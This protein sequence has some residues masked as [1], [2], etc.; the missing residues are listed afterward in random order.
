MPIRVCS[1]EP[2]TLDLAAM[3]AD[4]MRKDLFLEVDWMR[5]GPHSRGH[6]PRKWA[7]RKLVDA[8]R[9][10]P[11]SNPDGSTGIS[12][13]VD[14]GPW[15]EMNPVTGERWGANS[16]SNSIAHIDRL[17]S[18]EE[19]GGPNGCAAND[20]LTIWGAFDILKLGNL[21]NARNFAKVRGPVFR[22]GVLAHHVD[23]NASGAGPPRTLG[24]AR[25]IES[26]D[27]ILSLGYLNP[28][29]GAKPLEQG[30]TMMHEFGHALGL[31]HGGQDDTNLKPNYVS[32]MNYAFSRVGVLRNDGGNALQYSGLGALPDLDEF[33]LDE[34]EGIAGL[35]P[36]NPTA[37]ASFGTRWA[38]PAGLCSATTTQRCTFDSDCPSA[39]FCGTGVCSASLTVC[40]DD[41]DCPGIEFCAFAVCSS[42]GTPCASAATCPAGESCNDLVPPIGRN[43]NAA[44]VL[45]WN[46]NGSTDVSLVA[47]DVNASSTGD[48]LAGNWNDWTSLVYTADHVGSL[49]EIPSSTLG[50]AN[51]DLPY[52][53]LRL[54]RRERDVQIEADGD[55]GLRPGASTQLSFS[56]QNTGEVPDTYS[57][58]LVSDQGFASATLPA[59]VT[60]D[61]DEEVAI[62]ID[63]DVPLATP[64]GV[65]EEVP[66]EAP[67]QSDPL[68]TGLDGTIVDVFSCGDVNLDSIVDDADVRD[69]RAA[70][71]RPLSTPLGFEGEQRCSVVGGPDDCDLLDLVL[72]QRAVNAPVAAPGIAQ[73]CRAATL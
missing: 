28:S 53:I 19:I 39:E 27:F 16:Q 20:F 58:A 1:Y 72:L 60:L 49:I 44:G 33:A 41:V 54:I 13:H 5:R 34:S 14:A 10:A 21:N 50:S 24:I 26:P 71:L 37:L 2:C 51:Q 59:S 69:L 52:E 38:C 67:S 29:G 40:D 15:S 66:L 4:P 32:V 3:G 17:G 57:L 18:C 65:V 63:V 47:V 62:A 8:F 56:I 9:E 31:R 6:W 23:G 64:I 61:V 70:L 45:D 46:C 42:S 22:Y 12:L 11:V 25:N 55:L 35:V 7:V 30:A 36:G 43:P 73:V 68:V 48:V